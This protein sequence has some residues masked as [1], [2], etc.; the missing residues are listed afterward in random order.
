MAI[1][2]NGN[3]AFGHRSSNAACTFAG[4]RL[5]S[6]ANTMLLKIDPL[7]NEVEVCH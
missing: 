3:C 1:I 4:A 5:I 2:T 7:E 6:S